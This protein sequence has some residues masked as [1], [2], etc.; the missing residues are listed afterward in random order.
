MSRRSACLT[1]VF[2]VLAGP[3]TAQA[4]PTAQPK[5]LD[6]FRETEKPGHSRAHVVTEAKWADLNRTSG[7][8]ATYLALVASSGT[9]E[10]WWVTGFDSFDGLGKSNAFG[11]DN[12]SY[13]QAIGRIA[14][15]DGDHITATGRM[16][17]RAL[18]DAGHGAFPELA[19]MRVFSI[20]TIRMRP[21][22]E[23]AFTELG[24]HFAAIAG[25][26]S[27]IAGWRAYEVIAGAP[28]GTHLIFATF[29]S[30]AAVDANE[31]A[32][33][34]A[35]GGAGAHLEAAGKLVR[36]AVMSTDSRYFEV[37]PRMSL[38]SKEM[39]ADPFWGPKPAAKKA[40]P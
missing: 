32:W 9:P 2:I 12:P 35:M 7:Y 22:M 29:P 37:N 31:A 4:M 26:A 25:S 19:K 36:E 17:A 28:G 18:P 21:G 27:G 38:V 14:M 40:T 15:E 16:Q 30:W 8:P 6:I 1:A 10:V 24:K 11:A 20:L 39:A 23:P 5:L 13:T 3:L 34:Q 33:A